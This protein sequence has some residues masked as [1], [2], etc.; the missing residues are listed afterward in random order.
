VNVGD[1]SDRHRVELVQYTFQTAASFY[2]ANVG[3]RVAIA[4]SAICIGSAMVCSCGG[5][6]TALGHFLQE[7]EQ[8]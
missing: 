3:C 4:W 8:R 7:V 6:T 1:G 2:R 5:P